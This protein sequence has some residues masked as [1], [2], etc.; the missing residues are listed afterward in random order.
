MTAQDG[1]ERRGAGNCV[2]RRERNMSDVK[3]VVAVGGCG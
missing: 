1:Y 2:D 3:E